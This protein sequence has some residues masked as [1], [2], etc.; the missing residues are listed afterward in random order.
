[1]LLKPAR[2]DLLCYGTES[3]ISRLRLSHWLLHLAFF[4]SLAKRRF[5]NS[6]LASRE[7]RVAS[8]SLS[9]ARCFQ[10]SLPVCLSV[11]LSPFK[12]GW[13]ASIRLGRRTGRAVALQSALAATA[14]TTTNSNHQ[15]QLQRR[16]TPTTVKY[17]FFPLKQNRNRGAK[18]AI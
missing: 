12:S 14:T 2:A 11:C 9:A 4:S 5:S 18:M 13:P 6:S 17:S 3:A 8:R 15:Q 7:S 16:H 1:M 10:L